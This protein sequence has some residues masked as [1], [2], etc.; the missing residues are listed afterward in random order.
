MCPPLRGQ[1][2]ARNRIET[3]VDN[4]LDEKL[5]PPPGD[6]IFKGTWEEEINAKIDPA[7]VDVFR[8]VWIGLSALPGTSQEGSMAALGLCADPYNT[9]NQGAA[10]PPRRRRFPVLRL[11]ELRSIATPHS[12]KSKAVL[13]RSF[14]MLRRS[15]AGRLALVKFIWNA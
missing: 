11:P 6:L 9:K 12:H 4:L 1:R 5:F 3:L 13:G 7:K 8:K 15:V 10:Q 14:R 2:R